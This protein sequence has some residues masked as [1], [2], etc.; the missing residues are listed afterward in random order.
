MQANRIYFFSYLVKKEKV[1]WKMAQSRSNQAESGNR[2]RIKIP[3]FIL[4]GG[5]FAKIL[6]FK[7][8]YIHT[9]A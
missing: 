6:F 8:A 1:K 7:H 3:G 4:F 9:H 5:F 2:M